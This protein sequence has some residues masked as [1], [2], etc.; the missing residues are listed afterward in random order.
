MRSILALVTIGLLLGVPVEAQQRPLKF[1]LIHDGEG[2]SGVD[3]WR[4]FLAT[5]TEQYARGRELLT[6][7]VNAVIGGLFA[8]GATAVDVTDGHGSGNTEPDLLLDKLDP[9]AKMI[10]KDHP[11]DPY[12]DLI[13]TKYDGVV[14]VDMHAKSG[15]KGFASHA[16]GVG[17][18]VFMNGKSLTEAEINGYAWG[19]ANT[20]IIF[21]SGDDK[22]KQD[23]A[24]PM[25]WVEYVTTKRATSASSAELIPLDQVYTDLKNGASKAVQ[26][27]SRM[28]VMKIQTP[29][30][31][32]LK[33]H[34]PA[35][36][37]LLDSVP[38][39]DY[40][41]ETVSFT[42]PDFITAYR[43]IGKLIRLSSSGGFQNL[44]GQML[45]TSPA[46]LQFMRAFTDS[47]FTRWA[48]VESGR[49]T[50]PPAVPAEVRNAGKKFHGDN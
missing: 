32:A 19:R 50:P 4:M 42:A 40:Q 5:Y 44:Q 9:R 48:D 38:G 46:G 49:W 35:S 33:A 20:P 2:I 43:G 36:L 11:F 8:G 10:F 39:I 27:L 47:L 24:T 15:S 3:N 21:V 16:L 28:K 34:S 22:L 12:I 18:E 29:V 23:L 45:R 41:N 25:P 31:A 1:L 7:D 13:D 6:A 30:K 26:N 17:V 37:A 14:M